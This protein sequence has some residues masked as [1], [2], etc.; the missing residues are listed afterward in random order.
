MAERVLKRKHWL[1]GSELSLVPHYDVLEPEELAEGTSG[2][3]RPTVQESGVT[4]HA[5]LDTGGLAGALTVG[6]GEAPGQLGACLRTGP[7][8]APGQAMP[9]D[10]G[11][12]RSP[13]KEEPVNPGTM[14][15]PEQ[16]G[17]MREEITGSA[18]PEGPVESFTGPSGQVGSMALYSVGTERQEGLGEVATGSPGQEGPVGLVGMATYSAETEL[19]SP[20][21]GE[22]QRQEDPVETVMSM[23]PG[24]MRF[25]QLYHEDLL[26]SLEEVALFPLEEVDVTGFRV[27]DPENLLTLPLLLLGSRYLSCTQNL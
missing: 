26:A 13:E 5:L 16:A 20:G 1:Q 7:V 9:I 4:E 18:S 15:S 23:D 21:Y 10:S 6:S 27:S 14:G 8:G 12:L 2:E 19:E 24:A 25:L 11:P 3:D 17:V 22:P